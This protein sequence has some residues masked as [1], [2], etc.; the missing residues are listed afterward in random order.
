MSI[1][2]QR[3]LSW[4]IAVVLI[5]AGLLLLATLYFAIVGVGSEEEDAVSGSHSVVGF[6]IAGSTTVQ[7]VSEILATVYSR[8]HPGVIIRVDGGGS[9]TGVRRAASGEVALGA[10]SRPLLDEERMTYPGLLVHQ[11]GGS[12]IV[13]I[14]SRDY[15]GDTITFEG[16]HALYNDEDD[17]VSA[18][19]EIR[20]I[21][22]VVQ[23]RDQSGT[24]EV[25]A[26]WLFPGKKA[27]DE[28]LNTLDR[29]AH[30]L[31]AK[32]EMEGNAGVLKTVKEASGAIGFVDFGY[33]EHDPG[34]KI[35]RILDQGATIPLPRQSSDIR[36]SIL[37]ELRDEGLNE[38]QQYIPGL[39]RPLSYVTNE[40]PDP[41]VAQFIAFVR[42]SDARRYFN[43]IGYFSMD[44]IN[45]NSAVK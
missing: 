36:S 15:P 14:A 45:E 24:E 26:G 10:L 6:T 44:E 5:V 17:D 2:G 32:L 18:L 22:V 28:S 12:G 8:S 27:V 23:R 20:N 21:R 16:L 43:E 41:E 9:G 42:S 39:T 4:L 31:I 19:Q 29:S 38:E 34:V 11:I 33:A 7:P 40:T 30:G 35:L 3:N 37:H 13:V 25:F 1:W